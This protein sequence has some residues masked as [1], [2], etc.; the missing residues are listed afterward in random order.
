MQLSAKKTISLLLIAIG[1]F[2]LASAFLIW[3][4]Q[5]RNLVE[6]SRTREIEERTA[7]TNYLTILNEPQRLL[8]YDYSFWDE[9]VSFV[10]S[11]D[12]TWAEENLE[13]ALSTFDVDV[14]WTLGEDRN[15]ISSVLRNSQGVTIP[16]CLPT[17]VAEALLDTLF[18]HFFV[19]TSEGLLEINTAPIQP[20]ADNSRVTAPKGY[21]ITGRR[22]DKSRLER[23][24]RLTGSE[25]K[26]IPRD[27]SNKGGN[28]CDHLTKI[29]DRTISFHIELLNSEN[30]VIACLSVGNNS[31]IFA[32]AVTSVKLDFYIYSVFI[33]IFI[34]II[35]I[36]SIRLIYKPIYQITESLKNEDPS[37]VS[38]L[39]P[40]NHEFG[41]LARLVTQSFLQRRAL[42][43]EIEKQKKAEK[44]LKESEKRYR[45]LVENA[46]DA[47]YLLSGKRYEYVNPRFCQITGYT[48]EEVTSL[49]FDYNVLIPEETKQFME[50][51]Y[52]ARMRGEKIPGEYQIK[53]VDR[54][55]KL[56]DLEV[57]T[58]S[59]SE[60]PNSLVLGIMRDVTARKQAEMALRAMTERLEAI[61]DAVPD[62]IMEVNQNRTYTWANKAGFEFFGEDVIGKNADSYFFGIQDT[63]HAVQPLFD[64]IGD[65]T[66]VESWQRRKDGVTRLLAWWC[67]ALKDDNGNVVGALSSA[68]DITERKEI[69][70]SVK[71]SEAKYRELFENSRDAI[72]ISTRNGHFVDVNPAMVELFGYS[73]SEMLEINVIELY[74]E[75]SDRE[76]LLN[77][78][79]QKNG[80]LDYEVK[81]KKKNGVVIDCLISANIQRNYTGETGRYQGIIRDI[82]SRKQLEEQLLQAQKMESVGRL[83][84][85]VAHDFNNMLQAVM[86][87]LELAL[88]DIEPDSELHGYLNIAY[89][90]AE[91]SA[92][93]TRQLLAFARKQIISPKVIDMNDSIEGI[94]KMLRRLLGEKVT[95]SW[96]PGSKLWYVRID[97]AQID[98]ILANLCV[99][100]QDA[101]GASG[102][103][104][105][106]TRNTIVNE[107]FCL[108]HSD[109]VPGDY[110]VLSVKDNGCGMSQETLERIF[111]PFYTTKDIG[112]GTGLG[113][114]TVYGI[115]RQNNGFIDVQ[116]ELD[117]GSKFS[118]YFPRINA[119]LNEIEQL[120]ENVI[121]RS[122]GELVLLV[123]DE[124]EILEITE[125]MLRWLDYTVLTA[126]HPLEALEIVRNHKG[127]I[128]LMVTDVVMPSMNGRELFLQIKQERPEMKCLYMS[129]HNED[130]LGE[131]G[132]LAEDINFIQK[133]FIIGKLAEKVRESLR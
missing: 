25:L 62:I 49:D 87:N 75:F 43:D 23:I 61:F 52:L 95:L 101:V 68:E 92:N 28:S 5:Q 60:A 69:E 18:N 41:S 1:L 99:N 12:P 10:G 116:S 50:E 73:R 72:F 6:L 71:L 46:F 119:E 16:S 40:K 96:K 120:K 90:S 20:S 125:G 79:E 80:I 7:F 58:V 57:S 11:N 39:V 33:I 9:M 117:K 54:S 81:L 48:F 64:G 22:W 24:S 84:G 131:K 100:A 4:I 2:F 53:I 67:R 109:A 118:L 121:P 65:V 104:D 74:A 85:G 35:S 111:E 86:G 130:I 106:E 82:T 13:P 51:R 27:L 77:Q 3:N 110:V 108:S 45:V 105:V 114:A 31:E 19:M 63:Y 93:L 30:K 36:F 17:E 26:I 83:A 115:V 34:S 112:K 102:I 88:H 133:P 91:R 55:G 38:D 44:A 123:E 37:F 89:N 97:P 29:K 56:I 66:Y 127:K 122:Q 32:Q 103:V 21:L 128:D 124:K 94:L 47:I 59:I 42:N 76:K 107:E 132:S 126:E 113:L 129:G 8:T 78:I 70:E 98:Q 15:I 14:I